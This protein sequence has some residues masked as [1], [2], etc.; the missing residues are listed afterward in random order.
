MIPTITIFTDKNYA[1]KIK[2]YKY[3]KPI[4]IENKSKNLSKFI[5]ESENLI[6]NKL[7]S[8]RKINI[9]KIIKLL[10]SF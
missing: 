5:Y 6:L 10:D 9:E 2:Y 3:V 1:K 4:F 7:E 8:W